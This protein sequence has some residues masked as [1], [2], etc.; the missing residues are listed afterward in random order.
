[1]LG[2]LT[3]NGV[4]TVTNATSIIAQGGLILS[5]ITDG[6]WDG[7]RASGKIGTLSG[8]ATCV[9]GVVYSSAG[10]LTFSGHG[11]DTNDFQWVYIINDTF[12]PTFTGNVSVECWAGGGGGGI[13]TTHGTG[14]GGG[15]AYAKKNSVAVTNGNNY[16]VNVGTGGI[17]NSTGDSW[18]S[19]TGTVFAAQGINGGNVAGGAGGQAVNCIGDVIHEGGG[20]GSSLSNSGGAGGGSSAGTGSNGNVGSDATGST[21]ANGGAAV[22]G[23][24]A[25]G[26]GGNNGSNGNDGQILGGGGGGC[27]ANATNPGAGARGQIIV[28]RL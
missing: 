20:G 6:N 22:T 7:Y 19:T 16:T 17:Q 9:V 15:G 2:K 12:T 10:T 28:R 14:G 27:G 21:G 8:T 23:G 1:M 26:N 4:A 25:G 24:G 3:F 18:F 5:G 13:T 11:S